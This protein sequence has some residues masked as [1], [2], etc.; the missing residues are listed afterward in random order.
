MKKVLCY[1]E[2]NSRTGFGH[3]SRI[4]ILLEILKLK[5]V[6]ILTENY[7]AALKFFRHQNVI[8]CKNI[9]I[10][11]RKNFL[12][13]KLLIIDPPYYPNQKKQQIKFSKKFKSIYKLENKNFKVIWLTDEE[14][15]SDKFCDLLI[16][17]YPNAYKFKNFYRKKNNKIKM[18]LGIYAFLFSRVIFKPRHRFQRKHIL[19]SFGGDDPK[20]LTLKYFNVFKNLEGKKFFIVNAETYKTLGKFNNKKNL[21]IEK[22]KPMYKYVTALANSKYY[23]ATPS[24]IMFEAMALNI[25]GNVIP[26]QK[27]Q[28]KM[29]LAFKKLKFVNLLPQY[30]KLS[31][32]MLKKKLINTLDGTKNKSF[33]FNKKLALHTQKTLRN[34]FTREV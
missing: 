2:F 15:P 24:N 5:N 25:K 8:K 10:Y 28:Y 4:K 31:R 21:I 34:F 29:G 9:F 30:K 1:C 22:K 19:I 26:I 14:K 11:L 23:I 32:K 20:N 6:D 18:V 3:F 12:K 17:D 27:R 7:S 33:I 16:N 13:Y